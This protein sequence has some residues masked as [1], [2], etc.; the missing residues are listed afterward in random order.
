MMHLLCMANFARYR[1]NA[2]KRFLNH[3]SLRD[4]MKI[5]NFIQGELTFIYIF[6]V[7]TFEVLDVKLIF[8]R[9]RSM[10]LKLYNNTDL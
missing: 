1:E 2:P 9:K 5:S 3:Q 4:L 10:R 6:D 7:L 8:S